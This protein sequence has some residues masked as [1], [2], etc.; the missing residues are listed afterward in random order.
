MTTQ[1]KTEA[2]KK[3]RTVSRGAETGAFGK[4]F[5]TADDRRN[6]RLFDPALP[7]DK[8]MQRSLAPWVA[9][10]AMW[11]LLQRGKGRGHKTTTKPLNKIQETYLDVSRRNTAVREKATRPHPG[12]DT[13]AQ[14]KLWGEKIMGPAGEAYRKALADPRRPYSDMT[15]ERVSPLKFN[16]KTQEYDR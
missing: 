7:E 6:T 14:R 8:M 12:Y 10:T 1:A 5:N 2:P 9:K 11:N 13:E 3:S 15:G 4:S 16:P